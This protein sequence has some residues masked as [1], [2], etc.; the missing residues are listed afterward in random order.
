[1][2]ATEIEIAQAG[3]YWGHW[4][5]GH[6][7]TVAELQR[8]VT[9][10][11]GEVVI[12]YEHATQLAAP[13]EPVPAAGWINRVWVDGTS[14]YGEATWTERAEEMI[15]A[16]EY[17]F[18]SPVIDPDSIDRGTA[19]PVGAVLDTVALTN[20]PF[21]DAMESVRNSAQGGGL[22]RFQART[23]EAI[24]NSSKTTSPSDD[25]S[26]STQTT[27]DTMATPNGNAESTLDYLRRKL[28]GILNSATDNEHDLVD[29]A[30][31]MASEASEAEERK[32]RI[33][34]LKDELAEANS[35]VEELEG[36]VEEDETAEAE[37]QAEENK[38][39]LNSA[40]EDGK[41][42]KADREVYEEQ[43]AANPDGMR[44]ILNSMPAGQA[45]P[46]GKPTAPANPGGSE[47]RSSNAGSPAASAF[48]DYASGG[49]DD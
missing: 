11:S 36:Q 7:L 12:D 23:G 26:S 16:D 45:L 49:A 3:E 5:G 38:K 44:K 29:D 30:R 17:R 19:E 4:Q 46:D 41:I 39:L 24:L 43:L 33:E 21:M 34:E 28:K 31:Q 27:T 47:E 2:A 1:M 14:L 22:G 20:F 8:I 35:R 9:N 40:I 32:T 25:S 18:L 10:F 42:R 37:A 13:G 48:M 15:D 6:E